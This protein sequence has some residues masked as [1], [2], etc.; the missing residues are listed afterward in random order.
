[1]LRIDHSHGGIGRGEP[2]GRSGR[3]CWP[4]FSVVAFA[5]EERE[6]VTIG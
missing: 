4:A 1:M 3:L 6:E 2:G 5:G